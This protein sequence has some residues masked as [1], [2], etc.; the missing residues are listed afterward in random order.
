MEEPYIEKVPCIA[1]LQAPRRQRRRNIIKFI[2][3]IS[4]KFG[5]PNVNNVELRT[6]LNRVALFQ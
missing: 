3:N 6:M 2:I 5:Y 4:I 1:M